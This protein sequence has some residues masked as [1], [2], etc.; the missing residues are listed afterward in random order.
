MYIENVIN[1]LGN[2]GQN[3]FLSFLERKQSRSTRVDIDMCQSIIEGR[4]LQLTNKDYAVR[5]R[6][7]NELLK[8]ISLK[9]IEDDQTETSQQMNSLNLCTYLFENRMHKDAWKLLNAVEQSAQSVKNYKVL[10][11]CYILMIQHANSSF[12]QA[13]TEIIKKRKRV[14]A[15]LDEEERLIE[16]LA[17]I[18]YD[19][20]Q[21]KQTGS[22]VA[23]DLISQNLTELLSANEETLCEHPKQLRLYLEALR[24]IYLV[25][26]ELRKLC[27]EMDRL[28][29]KAKQ[30]DGFS[31]HNHEE[32]IRILY[33]LCH[34]Y[35]RDQKF[36][37]SLELI[38]EIEQELRSVKAAYNQFYQ[39]KMLALKSALYFL[40]G[41][42]DIAIRSVEHHLKTNKKLSVKNSLNLH[43]NLAVYYGYNNEFKKANRL[44]VNFHH[45]D[46]WAE[47]RMGNDWIVRKNLIEIMIQYQL[48]HDD[49]A[50]N[51]LNSTIRYISESELLS[52][53]VQLMRF[54]RMFKKFLEDQSSITDLDLTIGFENKMESVDSDDEMKKL[55]FYCWFKAL[56]AKED[57]Y[58]LFMKT[59]N[60]L[61]KQ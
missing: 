59:I 55:A 23:L 2:N 14:K 33:M 29:T 57:F 4:K 3:E 47:K 26:K 27:S 16:I 34:A 30:I 46:A 44:F 42:L 18:R 56:I 48:G 6:I 40:N 7:K 51:K 36:N 10:D 43:L 15:F 52:Q 8:F 9:L 35:Y 19:I 20:H 60:Q 32:K 21:F 12:A 38:S 31:I 24:S 58:Q 11:A 50:L 5:H 41:Q 54:L 28:Y 17:I 39:S 22:N 25:K 53:D 49:I 13:L 61:K 45:S 37:R 1:L